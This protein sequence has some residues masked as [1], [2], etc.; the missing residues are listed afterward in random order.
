[1]WACDAITIFVSLISCPQIVH[2]ISA[3]VVLAVSAI[4]PHACSK[5]TVTQ[6]KNNDNKIK[7]TVLSQGRSLRVHAT[8][9]KLIRDHAPAVIH[10]FIDDIGTTRLRSKR[11]PC[12]F[13]AEK[14]WFSVLTTQKNGTRAKK[15]K[16]GKVRRFSPHFLPDTIGKRLLYAS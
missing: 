1:M 11:V 10:G 4:A 13:G 8:D 14:D 9:S 16:R 2:C 7:C 6:Q 5:S 3:L 15:W 12:C